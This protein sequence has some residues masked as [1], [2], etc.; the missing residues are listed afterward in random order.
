MAGPGGGPPRRSHTKSRKGCDTCKR[1]HIRCDENFPQ[2]RNCTK[3]KIRCPYND[4][5]VTDT[6]RSAT[7]EKP[8][9]MWTPE[10]E[11]S[12]ADWKRTGIFPFPA[13]DVYPAIV[14][15]HYN[16]QDLRLIHHVASLYDTL[17]A[18][19]ANNFTLWT[20][21][22]PTLLRIGATHPM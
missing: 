13:L 1:R 5:Q 21:H 7:P 14:P 9:L 11:A 8:D 20:R 4:V 19:D 17:A 3:H 12:I 18:M 16:D 22:I 6:K 15:S 10:I 2:C